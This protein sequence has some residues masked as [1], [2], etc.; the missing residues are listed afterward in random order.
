LGSIEID[1]D[2]VATLNG[3]FAKVSDGSFEVTCERPLTAWDPRKDDDF[4]EWDW[5]YWQHT[6]AYDH[7]LELRR[8]QE[9]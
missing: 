9:P 5:P 3:A 8:P 4:G 7:P 2:A 6:G 1:P